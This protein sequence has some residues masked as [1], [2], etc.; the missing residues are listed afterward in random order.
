[1]PDRIHIPRPETRRRDA[2]VWWPD[3]IQAA[4]L[5]ALAVAVALFVQVFFRVR[6]KLSLEG[7]RGWALLIGFAIIEL[8][9]LVRTWRQLRK[10]WR[11]YRAWRRPEDLAS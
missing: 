8:Y 6:D 9:L 7:E 5:L 2:S 10:A 11:A 3:A 1:M 4:A